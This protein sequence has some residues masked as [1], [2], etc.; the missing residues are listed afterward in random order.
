MH[1]TKDGRCV[2]ATLTVVT[3]LG[4]TASAVAP[5]QPPVSFTQLDW[6]RAMPTS[7]R[8]P[9]STAS[10]IAMG[11]LDRP[12]HTDGAIYVR[13]L[14]TRQTRRSAS[15]TA[16]SRPTLEDVSGDRVVYRTARPATRTS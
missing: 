4:G 5:L 15:V 2:V 9:S 6:P 11:V 10:L 12:E 3:L 14:A 8:T 13:N 7:K 16:S 1:R